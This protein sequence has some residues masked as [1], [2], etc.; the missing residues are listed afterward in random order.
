MQRLAQMARHAKRDADRIRAIRTFV[1]IY[2]KLGGMFAL[3]GKKTQEMPLFSD[4]LSSSASE[5]PHSS[6]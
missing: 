5:Q 3:S 4:D 6:L 1:E 2:R